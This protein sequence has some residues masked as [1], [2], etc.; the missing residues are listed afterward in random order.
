MVK[1]NCTIFQG[2][3]AGEGVVWR[4]T[5]MRRML[6]RLFW[7]NT[8]TGLLPLMLVV[9]KMDTRP[10]GLRKTDAGLLPLPLGLVWTTDTGPLP[11]PLGWRKTVAG[12]LPLPL[13]EIPTSTN[14][15]PHPLPLPLPLRWGKMDAGPLP[16]PLV[17]KSRSSPPRRKI[18]RNQFNV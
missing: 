18:L 2:V 14:A 9:S 8:G 7:R 12:P 5:K 10:L 15:R 1:V 4:S 17:L 16:L 6:R 11:L 13:L 3:Q